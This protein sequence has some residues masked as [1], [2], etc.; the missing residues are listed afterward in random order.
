LFVPVLL[1]FLW[2]C[3]H[4][5]YVSTR[6][7]P[8]H[9]F[10]TSPQLMC[11][12]C[13]G[14]TKPQLVSGSEWIGICLK[15]VVYNLQTTPGGQMP[16]PQSLACDQTLWNSAWLWASP[17]KH[18]SQSLTLWTDPVFLFFSQLDNCSPH[19]VLPGT[20]GG[21][22]L[23]VSWSCPPKPMYRNRTKVYSVMSCCHGIFMAKDHGK[24]S[25]TPLTGAT[26]L[27]PTL[28]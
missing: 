1:N 11:H 7:Y 10:A 15:R 20:G 6:W 12:Y 3:C 13:L 21:M 28:G 5:P 26:G 8:E 25:M 2:A 22:G 18:H 16:C 9:R 19:V 4:F 14:T 23:L 24:P 27:H 17:C